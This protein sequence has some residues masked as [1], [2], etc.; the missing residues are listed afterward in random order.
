MWKRHTLYKLFYTVLYISF[1]FSVE[2]EA[3]EEVEAQ[4]EKDEG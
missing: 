4:K 2:E 1:F 3:Y